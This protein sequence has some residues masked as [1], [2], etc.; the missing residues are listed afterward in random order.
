V[1]FEEREIGMTRPEY[2]SPVIVWQRKLSGGWF[3]KFDL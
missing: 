1:L 2:L 3:G